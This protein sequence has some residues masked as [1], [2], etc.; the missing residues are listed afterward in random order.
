MDSLEM[1]PQQLKYVTDASIQ[2]TRIHAD[3]TC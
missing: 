2:I 3:L 1:F